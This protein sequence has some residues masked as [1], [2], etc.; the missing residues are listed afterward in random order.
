VNRDAA[1]L[2]ESSPTSILGQTLQENRKINKAILRL[3]LEVGPRYSVGLGVDA[4]ASYIGYYCSKK[5]I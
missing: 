2:I 1:L 4:I 3:D 5:E